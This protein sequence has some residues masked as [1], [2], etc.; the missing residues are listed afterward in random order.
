MALATAHPPPLA[1]PILAGN[2][3][4]GVD[5]SAGSQR[6]LAYAADVAHSEHGRLTLIAVVPPP[7]WTRMAFPPVG[8]DHRVIVAGWAQVL[9]AAADCLPEDVPV[10]TRFVHGRPADAIVCRAVEGCHD[11]VVVGCEGRG[12]LHGAIGGV[13]RKVARRCPVPVLVVRETTVVGS[14]AVR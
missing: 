13:S 9:H 5:G 4:V 1:A 7:L 14:L 3:L 6:A 11:L 12:L 8:Y 2:I 10:T